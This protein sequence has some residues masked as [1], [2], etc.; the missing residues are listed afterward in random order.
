MMDMLQQC[1]TGVDK[2]GASLCLATGTVV[3]KGAS[4]LLNGFMYLLYKI[5]TDQGKQ[6]NEI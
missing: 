6:S 3:L 1:V 2:G 4:C 5:F